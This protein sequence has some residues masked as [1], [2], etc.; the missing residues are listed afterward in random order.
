MCSNVLAPTYALMF[1]RH[2]IPPYNYISLLLV[3]ITTTEQSNCDIL[4]SHKNG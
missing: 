2:F 1:R 4:V 3:R